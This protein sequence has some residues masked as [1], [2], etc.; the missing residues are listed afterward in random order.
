M[1]Q[2]LF[3]YYFNDFTG[4]LLLANTHDDREAG[5]RGGLKKFEML[6][7][8]QS[9]IEGDTDLPRD[10]TGRS[11]GLSYGTYDK[12]S[13][14]AA[15]IKKIFPKEPEPHWWPMPADGDASGKAKVQVGG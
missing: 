3:D 11:L 7:S 5:E 12:V 1:L 2:D 14:A 15:A 4:E 6:K 8:L 9:F 10:P 13:Q